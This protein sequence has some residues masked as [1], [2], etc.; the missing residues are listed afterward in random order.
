[1]AEADPVP[2]R[3][4]GRRCKME[5]VQS[6]SWKRLRA[7]T[8]VAAAF[9]MV[10]V[11][12]AGVTCSSAAEP[13]QVKAYPGAVDYKK[14]SADFFDCEE[15][16]VLYHSYLTPDSVIKAVEFYKTQGFSVIR[17][18]SIRSCC[19]SKDS[20]VLSIDKKDSTVYVSIENW[21]SDKENQLMKDTLIS[22]AIADQPDNKQA[23]FIEDF[24]GIVTPYGSAK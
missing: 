1:M 15:R 22:I 18:D 14:G 6:I 4:Q 8:R 11:L 9:V 19:I 10:S 13:L 17:H 23:Q 2:L 5:K 24:Q 21:W 20:Y 3:V 7:V 16:K 12:G